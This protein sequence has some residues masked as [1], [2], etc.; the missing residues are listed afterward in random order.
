[1]DFEPIPEEIHRS[2]ASRSVKNRD[3]EGSE[4]SNDKRS[5]KHHGKERKSRKERSS[6]S[7]RGDSE[8]SSSH[9]RRHHSEGH[10]KSSSGGSGRSEGKSKISHEPLIAINS[11]EH[12]DFSEIMSPATDPN[13]MIRS[14]DLLLSFRNPFCYFRFGSPVKTV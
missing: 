11:G 14:K 2:S 13:S 10:S 4:R 1:M 9:H 8:S 5:D 7:S 3:H 12:S 6:R